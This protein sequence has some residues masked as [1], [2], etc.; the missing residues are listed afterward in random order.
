MRARFFLF[1]LLLAPNISWAHDAPFALTSVEWNTETG[2]LEVIHRLHAHQAL[3]LAANADFSETRRLAV[4]GLHV[5]QNFEVMDEMGAL[6]QLSVIG[7]EF[8][9]DYII[10]YQEAVRGASPNALRIRNDILM[11]TS[12]QQVNQ[13]NL[14]IGQ[15]RQTLM[16]NESH[17]GAFLPLQ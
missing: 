9:G 15:G 11:Q 4:I 13:V 16:F 12:Q 17:R 3:M 1:L 8:D 2:S 14:N 6:I 5:Q 7:A 10:V